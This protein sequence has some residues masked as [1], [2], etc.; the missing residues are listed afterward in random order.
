MKC[1]YYQKQNQNKM[2][3]EDRKL[4]NNIVDVFMQKATT[5][6]T[7]K[8]LEIMQ[9]EIKNKEENSNDRQST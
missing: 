7:N 9:E 2:T 1:A 6:G 3:I 4:L 5:V 8:A